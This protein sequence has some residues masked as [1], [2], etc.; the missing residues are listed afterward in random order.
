MNT[1]QI[2]AVLEL[3]QTLNFNKAAENL[4]VS[5][6]TLSYEIKSFEDEIGFRIFHRSGKGA[7]LTPAGSQF[8]AALRSIREE[9]KNAVEQGQNF[10]A[11][12]SDALTIGLPVR[13]MLRFLPQAIAKLKKKFPA[14]SVT[15]QFTGFY[16]PDA[17]LN[18][19][20]DVLIAMDFELK[21]VP[22]IT[23]YPLY[24]CGIS[25]ITQKDDPLTKKKAVAAEDLYGRTLLVG[26]GSPPA[27][28]K[29]Q[30]RLVKTGKIRYFNSA[31]HDTTLTHVAAGSAVC[32]APAFLNDHTG[33][34]G[35]TPFACPEKFDIV[36]CRHAPDKRESLLYFIK[37]LQ[38]LH[39]EKD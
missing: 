39:G 14:V 18:N 32:L 9:L 24:E 25:L 11:E 33:E 5:Q 38:K 28:R 36:L 27:L 21:H 29:V 3:A 31:D 30:Q 12:Y 15:P 26:G 22:D 20:Q 19:R 10:S 1:K 13:S 6:P 4:C 34:F 8:C 16:A 23:V 35:W 17:F 37:T 2:N 7:T